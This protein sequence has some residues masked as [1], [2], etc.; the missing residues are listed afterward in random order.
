MIDN[1]VQIGHNVEIGPGSVIVA[2][3]GVAGSSKLAEFVV[4][5][6]QAGVAGHLKIGAGARIAAQSGVMR[7]VAPGE[8]V[9]G[10]PA[11]PL[12]QLERKSGGEGKRGSGGVG[13]G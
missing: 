1:L 7:D 8:E 3:A 5:A 10:S 11:M 6:A 2:Q 9:G 12:R 13:R 4:L